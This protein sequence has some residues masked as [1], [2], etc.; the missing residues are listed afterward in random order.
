MKRLD[1]EKYPYHAASV[2]TLF[3]LMLLSKL[4]NL[5]FSLV[6]MTDINVMTLY[7]I[8]IGLRVLVYLN[9]IFL[10]YLFIRGF[11]KKNKDD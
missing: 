2:G 11:K 1:K 10:A 8:E 7:Y 3:T 9:V 5:N 4:R 6:Q